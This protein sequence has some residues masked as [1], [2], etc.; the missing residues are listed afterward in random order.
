MLGLCAG[1]IHLLL[2]LDQAG[3][4]SS[5]LAADLARLARDFR[6]DA[7][8]ALPVDPTDQPH[9][10]I[11]FS[12]AGGKTVEYLVRPGDILRT[13]REGEKVRHFD[14][15]RRPPKAAV[16]IEVTREGSL[17]FASLVVDR[18]PNGVDDSLY[19]ELRIEAELGKNQ[20]LT[21]RAE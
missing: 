2:K 11:K 3:R 21:P 20:R 14:L 9:Q 13:L 1:M 15:Y 7:H 6:A 8:A 16:S 17:P 19:H 5:D 10:Q 18:P 4:A 12:I